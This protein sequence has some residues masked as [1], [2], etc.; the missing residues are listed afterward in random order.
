M[1][2]TPN[3]VV[4]SR[5]GLSTMFTMFRQRRLRWL[6]HKWRIKD[7]SIPKIF[8][9]ESSLLENVILGGPNYAIEMCVS[10]TWRN[11]I[12]IQTNGKTV[13]SGEITCKPLKKLAKKY[14]HCIKKQTQE[15]KIKNCQPRVGF[16]ILVWMLEFF[17]IEK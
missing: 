14:N 4:L 16:W 6:G 13:P 3:T 17:L 11:W 10:K 2:I 9:T 8:C 15:R 7:R 5:C 1:S 12:L